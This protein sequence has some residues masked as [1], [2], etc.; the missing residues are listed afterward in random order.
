[1]R[2]MDRFR[3]F[4]IGR[5][6]GD[7]LNTV[8][9]IAAF[10][11]F[12]AASIITSVSESAACRV[13]GG[14]LYFAAL[15]LIGYTFFR[16]FSKNIPARR[17]EY[18]WYRL[19]IAD[20]VTRKRNELKTRKAQSATHEFFKCPECR[21]IVRV[22]KGKGTIRITCPKCGKTFIKKT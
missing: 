6:G 21:Q 16:S 18:E 8:M 4:M 9:S 12:A 13:I 20:P 1:M 17:K 7:S 14:I 2:L 15:A 11:G 5:Y 10:I 22:P 19:H 3:Q